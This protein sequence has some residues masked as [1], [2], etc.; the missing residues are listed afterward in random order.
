MQDAEG[1]HI[2]KVYYTG[3]MNGR[4]TSRSWVPVSLALAAA[5]MAGL[6]YLNALSNPFVYDDQRVIVDNLAIRSLSNVR[7]L[8]LHDRFRPVVNIT[9]AI[10]YAVWGP[11]PFGFH[12][13]S[14]LFHV[15]NVLM[16]FV[17][18]RKLAGDAESSRLAADRPEAAG[19]KKSGLKAASKRPTETRD[20]DDGIHMHANAAAFAAAAVWA[21]HPLMTQAVGYLSGRS[22]VVCAFFFLAA[23]LCL[24]PWVT[25]GRRAWLALAIACWLLA[26]GSKEVAV[27]LPFV[28]MAYERLLLGPSD[29]GARRRAV[30]VYLPMLAFVAL[31]GAARMAVFVGVENASRANFSWANLLVGM[32]VIRRYVSLMFLASPQSIF[33]TAQVVTSAMRPVVML[34]AAWMIALGLLAWRVHRRAPVVTFGTLWFLLMLLPSVAMLVLDVGEPMA[35]QRLYLAGGGFAFAT[36]AAFG[37]LHDWPPRHWVPAR[38]LD[39]GRSRLLPRQPGR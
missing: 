6:V 19:G 22:E 29:A 5:L 12:V 1:G 16:L 13:T 36:G 2:A 35:E 25:G 31:A 24:H 37:R 28:L 7:A 38:V 4:L 26:L 30:R 9:Y 23:L 10:D 32:D 8:L 27:M 20:W 39:H 15:A 11:G 14:V 33:H 34:D 21:V 18:M 17:L 3:L